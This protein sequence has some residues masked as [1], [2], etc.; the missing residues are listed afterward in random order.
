MAGQTITESSLVARIVAALKKRGA[1]VV[2]LHGGPLQQAGLPDLLVLHLGQVTFL[3]V[4]TPKGI[5]SPLQEHTLTRIQAHGGTAV[6]VRT[7]DEAIVMVFGAEA[8]Q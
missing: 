1:W 8:L 6:V 4:K 2:K 3:E 7:L 5:V